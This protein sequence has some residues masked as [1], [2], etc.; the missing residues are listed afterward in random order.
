MI[1]LKHKILKMSVLRRTKKG[2]AADLALPPKIVIPS[3]MSSLLTFYQVCHVN[4]LM[5]FIKLTVD[6]I[7]DGRNGCNRERLLPDIVH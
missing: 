2:R 3:F 7:E 6:Y 5:G 4:C 1:L